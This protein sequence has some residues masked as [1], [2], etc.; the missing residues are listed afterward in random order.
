M[1]YASII[2]ELKDR[3]CELTEIVETLDMAVEDDLA[4]AY[5]N[6]FEDG[7]DYEADPE[8]ELELS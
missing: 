6:G 1:S 7:Q 2:Q 3:I 4:I 8:E 5:Q